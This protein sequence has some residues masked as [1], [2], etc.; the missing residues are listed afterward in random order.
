MASTDI[1]EKTSQAIDVQK[2]HIEIFKTAHEPGMIPAWADEVKKME[3]LICFIILCELF[4]IWWLCFYKT[5]LFY[6]RAACGLICFFTLNKKSVLTQ[7]KPD[8]TVMRQ[9][10]IGK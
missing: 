6:F 3:I 8:G 7:T 1:Q 2:T 10:F 5:T 4:L 9:I